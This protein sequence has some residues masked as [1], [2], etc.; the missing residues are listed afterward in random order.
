MQKRIL[1]FLLILFNF[2]GD[3]YAQEEILYDANTINNLHQWIDDRQSVIDKFDGKLDS[4]INLNETKQTQKATNTYINLINSLQST[5]KYSGNSNQDNYFELRALY[6]RLLG[7][8]K[9]N[10]KL[11]DY[12]EN[13]FNNAIGIVSHKISKEKLLQYLLKNKKTSIENIAYYNTH[14]AA[15]TFLTNALNNYPAEVLKQFNY[16]Q[17]Q[18]YANH[19]VEQAARISPN[20][21]K[22]YFPS[23]SYINNFVLKSNDTVIKTMLNIYNMLGVETKAYILS[24]FVYADN[25]PNLSAIHNL[26]YIPEN[27]LTALITLKQREHPIASKD[28]EDELAIKSLEWVRVINDLHDEQ[29]TSVRFANVKN[30]TAEQLYTLIVY[31][32]EEIFTSTFNGLYKRMLEKMD[33]TSGFELLKNNNFNRFRIFIKLCSGYNTLN[34]FLSTM[35]KAEAISLF[36]RFISAI[37]T[38]ENGLNDAVNVA[39]T[40]GSIED[41]TYLRIFENYLTKEFNNSLAFQKKDKELLYGLLLNVLYQKIVPIYTIDTMALNKY[42]LPPVDYLVIDDLKGASDTIYQMHFFFDDED[43]I[44]S[45]ATFINSFQTKGWKIESDSIITTLTKKEKN[46][47]IIYCNTPTHEYDGQ[48]AILDLFKTFQIA[49]SVVVHRGHSYYAMNTISKI[50][51]SAKV[52]YLGSC[53][54]YHNIAEVV[55]RTPQV[56]IIASKQIGTY[57]V[58][59]TLLEAISSTMCHEDTLRWS[60]VWQEIDKTLKTIGDV[61][62]GRFLD[63]VP[64]QKNM[65]SIFLSAYRKR[66]LLE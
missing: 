14:I 32:P 45:Y 44:V 29:D 13:I 11:L 65:G 23:K 35:S 5:I 10:Y 52:V 27:Y 39:D 17:K 22:K 49:P 15:D 7:I 42:K 6:D 1:F 36:E 54:A 62:Y 37:D 55:K 2:Y 57:V 63:Y 26:K 9:E 33:T 43:G 21:L 50:E 56:S 64:P 38:D 34:N 25:N 41:T 12:Y 47:V 16:Y 40:F 8:G 53:G 60:I 66:Q 19:I 46:T 30:M 28:I 61:G 59:N 48:K 58:N 18:P 3:I 31:S 24:D 20:T 51:P 4:I